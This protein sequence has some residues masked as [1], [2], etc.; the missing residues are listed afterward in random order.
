VDFFTDRGRGEP[1]HRAEPIE[2][3]A[4]RTTFLNSARL[5]VDYL[6][7]HASQELNPF[8]VLKDTKKKHLYVELIRISALRLPICLD[9]T[10][11]G[12]HWGL[13]CDVMTLEVCSIFPLYLQRWNDTHHFV[14]IPPVVLDKIASSEIE[15]QRLPFWTS[16]Y[17]VCPAQAQGQDSGN[18]LEAMVR[19]ILRLRVSE[20]LHEG[21]RLLVECLPFVRSSAIE[22]DTFSYE[23]FKAFPK[24]TVASTPGKTPETLRKFFDDWSSAG[25]SSV[26]PDDLGAVIPLLEHGV[27]YIPR[28]MSSSADLIFKTRNNVIVE[29][30]F[31]NGDQKV[32]SAVM[33]KELSKSC[34]H[35]STSQ[36]VFV[37][38]GLT[39]DEQQLPT[40]SR[41]LDSD[42]ATLAL[43]YPAGTTFKTFT[44]PA[45]L[46]VIVVLS[47]GLLSFL[48][49]ANVEVLRKGTLDLSD[50]SSALQ[51]PSR[52]REYDMDTT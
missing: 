20:E 40:A 7:S 50:M 25:F 24:I 44:T 34:C 14:F 33:A 37:M 39:T 21:S 43:R 46:E 6:E 32:K 26:H 1:D 17:N 23:A 13:G 45:N 49:A 3:N 12:S 8:R 15:Y 36:V 30:Q 16:L 9:K 29:W 51:S 5:F 28:P 38:I 47:P 41:V 52:R 19:H 27:F 10:I 4:R 42:G 22:N 31:K 18:L 48:T 11:N 35:C 2:Y